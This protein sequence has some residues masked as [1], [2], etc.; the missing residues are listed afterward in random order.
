MLLLWEH[1][2]SWVFFWSSRKS[3][4]FIRQSPFADFLWLCIFRFRLT[5][6]PFCTF[7]GFLEVGLTYLLEKNVFIVEESVEAMAIL[8]ISHTGEGL[9]SN[10]VYA[11]LGISA[12]SRVRTRQSLAQVQKERIFKCS[13][14]CSNISWVIH[15]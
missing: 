2:L 13:E 6:N 3:F 11:L 9:V 7:S 15:A 5:A 4:L 1:N 8:V 12:M 14:W 10:L